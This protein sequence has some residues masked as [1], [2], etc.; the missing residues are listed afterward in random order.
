MSDTARSLL[1]TILAITRDVASLASSVTRSRA[2]LAAENLFLRKQLALYQ[3]PQLKPRRADVAT[4]IILARLS[5]FVEWR[6]LLVIVKPET[7]IRLASK[8]IPIVLAVNRD[9]S[10]RMLGFHHC[11]ERGARASDSSGVGHSLQSRPATRES[12]S[13]H[14]RPAAW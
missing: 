3:E 10:P 5:R 4:R 6:H 8:R 12:G 13:R 14:S 9:D 7:L 2:Q 1:R 11:D